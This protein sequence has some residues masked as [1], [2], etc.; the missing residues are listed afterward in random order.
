MTPGG[1][2]DRT[3][4]RGIRTGATETTQYVGR[5]RDEVRLWAW[6]NDTGAA[7]C[8][9]RHESDVVGLIGLASW[10]AGVDGSECIR[11]GIRQNYVSGGWRRKAHTGDPN[12]HAKNDRKT[13][14]FH[15]V[16]SSSPQFGLGVRHLSSHHLIPSPPHNR[17]GRRWSVHDLAQT[18]SNCNAVNEQ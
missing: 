18:F 14:T 16:L 7:R 9:V 12:R 15:V 4:S 13:C 2:S 10:T 11:V 8:Q 5:T 3:R 17:T 1:K 6:I